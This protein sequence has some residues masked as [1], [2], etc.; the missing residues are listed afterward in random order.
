M[1]ISAN[2]EK[3]IDII[4]EIQM[5]IVDS[6]VLPFSRSGFVR[7]FHSTHATFHSDKIRILLPMVESEKRKYIHEY[8]K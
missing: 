4:K 5:Y 2:L 7:T 6:W 3:K 1:L 8:I